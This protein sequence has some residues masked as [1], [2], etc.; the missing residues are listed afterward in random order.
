MH[1]IHNFQPEVLRHQAVR[2]SVHASILLRDQDVALV[3]AV[4]VMSSLTVTAVRTLQLFIQLLR[5]FS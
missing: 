4:T 1:L 5:T 3:P 2:N